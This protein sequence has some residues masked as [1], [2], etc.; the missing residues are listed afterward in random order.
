MT[1]TDFRRWLDEGRPQR[2]LS[3]MQQHAT[4]C[5]SCDRE[6]RAADD[7]DA[8]LGIVVPARVS[9]GFNDAVML[10][11]HDTAWRRALAALI[12]V[13]AEPVVPVS[14]AFAIVLAWQCQRS[15]VTIGMALTLAPLLSLLSWRLFR[16]YERLTMPETANLTAP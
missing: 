7:L 15:G 4:I 14:L 8:L 3:R 12:Q 2:D 9:A 5:V 1:C 10:R 11:I 16:T 6:L 13:L